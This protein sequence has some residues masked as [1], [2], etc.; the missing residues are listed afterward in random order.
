MG[1][2]AGDELHLT[3]NWRQRYDSEA[4]LQMK[5]TLIDYIIFEFGQSYPNIKPYINIFM[6]TAWL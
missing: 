5:K 2:Y 6:N 1:E 3:E 4:S